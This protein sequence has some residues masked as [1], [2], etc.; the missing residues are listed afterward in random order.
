MNKPLL[1]E[2]L[3]VPTVL[4]MNKVGRASVMIFTDQGHYNMHMT[5][6]RVGFRIGATI[7]DIRDRGM[8]IDRVELRIGNGPIYVWVR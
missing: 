4:A 6:K 8:S 2:I 3:T 5:G 1:G 7:M